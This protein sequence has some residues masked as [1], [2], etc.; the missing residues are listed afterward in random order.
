MYWMYWGCL[1]GEDEAAVAHEIVLR[2][3]GQ[4]ILLQDDTSH[5]TKQYVS[6][7]VTLHNAWTAHTLWPILVKYAALAL[8]ASPIS[9]FPSVFSASAKRASSL[10]SPSLFAAI[11][12]CRRESNASGAEVLVGGEVEVNGAEADVIRRHFC[13]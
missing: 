6:L 8:N 3:R 7:S 5:K 13:I 10:S 2:R 9:L 11:S 4:C 1:V 12:S